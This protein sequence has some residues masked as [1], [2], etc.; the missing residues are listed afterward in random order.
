MR[1]FLEGRKLKFLY[2]LALCQLLAGPLVLL[3][4]VV[5]CQKA[6]PEIPR[7]GL[8]SAAQIAWHS[9]EFQ[10]A[11]RQADPICK[12]SKSSVPKSDPS[13]K[14][15][16]AKMPIIAWHLPVLRI[17]ASKQFVLCPDRERI[18]MPT[19]PQAPPGPPPR[20]G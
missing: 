1:G 6:A 11:L 18:W 2:L 10:A 19:W 12:D 4:V 15:L 14:L 20:V 16:K 13:L 3:Q 7:Q 17:F 9:D 5:F 8:V